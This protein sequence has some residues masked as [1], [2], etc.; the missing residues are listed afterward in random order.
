MTITKLTLDQDAQERIVGLHKN[1]RDR[2]TSTAAVWND[3]VTVIYTA[4][5]VVA[6]P[7]GIS[8]GSLWVM[9]TD[10]QAQYN[11][12][13]ADFNTKY[14]GYA[15][16]SWKAGVDASLASIAALKTDLQVAAD[17]NYKD[18]GYY[19][20]KEMTAAHKTYVAGLITASLG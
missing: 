14:V 12:L 8:L 13:D 18:G 20:I 7:N 3:G 19:L 6:S 10:F 1:V 15:A 9:L 17:A 5:F 2:M 16:S 4:V 11:A